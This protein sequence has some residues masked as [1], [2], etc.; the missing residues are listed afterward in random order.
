MNE[1]LQAIERVADWYKNAKGASPEQLLEAL[2]VVTSHLFTLETERANYHKLYED[3]IFDK[4]KDGDSVARAT[5]AAEVEVPELY[6][7]RRI[8]EASYKMA[9]AIR[10]QISY[11]KHEQSHLKT[12]Q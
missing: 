1:S 3:I 4:T 9:D 8:M 2:R 11:L 12:E 6:M 10:S 7:L 5:N